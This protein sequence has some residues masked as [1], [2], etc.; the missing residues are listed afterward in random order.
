M[1]LFVIVSHAHGLVHEQL[2]EEVARGVH[3]EVR[4]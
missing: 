2:L 4:K 1:L 3:I